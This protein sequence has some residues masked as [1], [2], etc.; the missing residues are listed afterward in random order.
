MNKSSQSM[1]S[2]TS[3]EKHKELSRREYQVAEL[4]A[5]GA[6]KKEIPDMLQKLYGGA[7][8]SVRTVENIV[9]SIYEKLHVGKTNELSAW[10]F[11]KHYGVDES[12]SPIKQLR[13]TIYSLLFLIIMIPQIC[14]LDQAVRPSRTRTVRTER[15]QRR[16]D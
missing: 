14:N 13:N 11:C 8:I 6:A 12:L 15:M 5:W 2:Q 9:R 10:W 7:L 1:V 16:K 4:I 3:G